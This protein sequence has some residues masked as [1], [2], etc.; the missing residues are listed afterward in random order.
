[1]AGYDELNDIHI[2]VLTE[3]GSIGAG[4]A[5]TA[6]SVILHDKVDVSMPKVRITSFDEAVMTLGGVE[7]MTAGV[8]IN[9]QGDVSG[10]IMFLLSMDDA[11]NVVNILLG[12]EDNSDELSEMALSAVEEVG[13]ILGSSYL[14]S[15]SEL[16]GLAINTSIPYLAIDMAGALMSVPVIE[17]GAVG[18]K[19]MFIEGAFK[20]QTESLA[21]NVI[22]FADPESLDKI[23]S[24]LGISI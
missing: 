3:I 16:T 19:I 12:M 2:D 7:T 22:M 1:M 6:L 18:D 5:A 20:G 14:N 10:M 17:F 21:S 9:Y 23:M 24:C 8:L 4:H 13:N 11:K 15:I